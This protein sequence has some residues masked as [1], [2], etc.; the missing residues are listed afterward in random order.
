MLER[1][2][3]KH[4]SKARIAIGQASIIVS[5]V[6]IAAL[7]GLLPNE[8]KVERQGR[9]VLAET[10]ATNASLYITR[11]DIQRMHATLEVTVKRN[12][13]L[14]SAGVR[15]RDDKILEDIARHTQFWL[16][17]KG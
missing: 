14:L 3:G 11:S 10:I 1:L 6:L 4:S 8:T 16:P 17:V 5:L 2:F 12:P 13:E 15:R 9:L 7:L